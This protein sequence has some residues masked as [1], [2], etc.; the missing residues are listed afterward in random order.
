MAGGRL[1]NAGRANRVLHGS[2][3]HR[4]VEMVAV[5]LASETV[6]VESRGREDPLPRPFA[7]GV[8]ILPEESPG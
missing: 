3:E 6:H 4:F 5:P 2:L 7:P 1:G 8:W